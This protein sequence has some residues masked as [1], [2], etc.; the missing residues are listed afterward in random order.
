VLPV[1]LLAALAAG[2]G[3][4]CGRHDEEVLRARIEAEREQERRVGELRHDDVVVR[5]EAATALGRVKTLGATAVAAL[6]GA[7][8]DRDRWVREAAAL[9]LREQGPGAAAAVEPLTRALDDEDE[10]V[11]WRAAEALGRVGPAAHAALDRLRRH[12]GDPHE[13][14]V[15][16]A[17][18][19][20][21]LERIGARPDGEPAAAGR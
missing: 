9:A 14:E 7:L 6:A 1:V 15:V 19:Q 3:A 4:S 11:R 8:S 16:R 17:A 18:S 13:V 5:R 2:S 10:Y 20:V 21:A 12:A